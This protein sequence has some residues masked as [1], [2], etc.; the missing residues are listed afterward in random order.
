MLKIYIYILIH[1]FIHAL[2]HLKSRK[3]RSDFTQIGICEDFNVWKNFKTVT[4]MSNIYLIQKM[5]N[6]DMES[7]QFK[8]YIY[9]F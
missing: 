7:L 5:D 4:D 2:N 6:G 1:I 9:Y 8:N 3:Q